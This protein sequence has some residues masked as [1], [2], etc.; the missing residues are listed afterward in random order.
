MDAIVV[1]WRELLVVGAIVIG[2]YVAEWF[3]FMR[4]SRRARE[5]RETI[6]PSPAMHELLGRLE[7][8]EAEIQALRQRVDAPKQP[9]AAAKGAELDKPGSPY[10]QA[11]ELAKQGLDAATLAAHCGISR[12]EAE[13]II[14]LHRFDSV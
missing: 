8:L 9:T 14:A 1:T 7:L 3:A 6:M 5:K 13:L 2:I 12:G 4:A 10:S 11:V